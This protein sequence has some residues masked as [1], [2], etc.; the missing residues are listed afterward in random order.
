MFLE[1][2]LKGT[3]SNYNWYCF[4]K[5]I[6][7]SEKGGFMFCETCAERLTEEE[8][9]ECEEKYHGSH[10]YCKKCRRTEY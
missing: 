3:I 8:I 10:Y 9:K 4:L 1:K 2:H 7:A 6:K 5:K